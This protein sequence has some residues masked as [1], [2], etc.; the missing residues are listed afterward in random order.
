MY[1]WAV[2]SDFDPAR[3]RS[4]TFSMEWP[5]RSGRWQA[6]PEIDKAAWFSLDRARVKTSKGLAGFLNELEE[7]LKHR[8]H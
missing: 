5:P 3:L 4:N 8:A 7:T 6:F 2:K 1:A